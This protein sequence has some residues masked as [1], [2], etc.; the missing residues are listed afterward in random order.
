[1]KKHNMFQ[2]K[3]NQI[4]GLFGR[5]ILSCNKILCIFLKSIPILDKIKRGLPI[6]LKGGLIFS[7][8]QRRAKLSH[9]RNNNEI[10]PNM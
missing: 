4:I 2:Y 3:R 10:N 7:T 8:P 1:M 9:S 6:V 5:N